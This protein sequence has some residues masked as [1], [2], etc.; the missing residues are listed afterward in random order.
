MTWLRWLSVPVLLGS[1]VV[2]GLNLAAPPGESSP[3]VRFAR[4]MSAHHRQAVDMSV[5]LLKRARDPQVRLLAQDLLLTQQAQIGQMS[6]WLM[7]WRRTPGGPEAPMAGMDLKEMGLAS[8]AEV[9]T[10]NTFPV[11]LAETRYLALMR[12]H[13]LGGVAMAKAALNTVKRP[14]TRAFAQRV[15]SAQTSEITAIDAMLKAR[16]NQ[17]APTASEM[18]DMPHD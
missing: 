2:L 17:D 13:H 3:E 9:A 18:G 6:G 7:T 4:D 8:P 10:L 14:E 12:Q 5:T 11:G 16:M 15:I 1:G